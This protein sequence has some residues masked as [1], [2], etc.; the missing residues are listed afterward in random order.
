MPEDRGDARARGTA[1]GPS[2]EISPTMNPK[3]EMLWESSPSRYIAKVS[4]A[5]GK[6]ILRPID[7]DELLVHAH[8]DKN[9][10]DVTAQFLASRLIEWT[11]NESAVKDGLRRVNLLG[12]K[13][14]EAIGSATG[15]K[16]VEKGTKRLIGV[17]DRDVF[18]KFREASHL[19]EKEVKARIGKLQKD[20]RALLRARGRSP[21][22]QVL[23]TGATGFL[24]KEILAQA[25][26]DR[27]IE[28]LVSV[29]RPEK[30]RDPKTKEVVRIL[31]PAQRGA[32]LLRRL[33]IA[34]AKAKKFVFVDGDIE[35]PDLGIAPKELAR[36]RK[37][38][39]HVIHC[40]ASVSFDD[41]YENSFRANVQGA[42][43]ALQFALSLQEARGS[44]FIQHIAI[45]TSYIHGRKKKTTA[46]ESALVFPRN[47]YNNFYELTKAM[48][49]L[50]TDY[51]LVEKG[52]RVSQL[53]PSIVIGHSRTG[54]NRGDTKV[55]NAPIN[56]FGRSKEAMDSLQADAM[57]RGKAWLIGAI[58]SSFPGDRSAE[59]N[60]VPV[61][62]VVQGILAALT[63][64]E[65]IG[66][67][68]HL[69]TDNR[70]RSEDIARITREEIG[71]NVRLADPT[72]FRNITLPIVKAALERGGEPKLANALEKLGTIFGGYGEWGQPIHDVGNDVRILGLPVRR[73]NTEHAFRMLC[74]HNKYVQDFGKVRDLDEIARRELLWEKVLS[75]IENVTGRQVAS[76][77]PDEFRRFLVQRIELKEFRQR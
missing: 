32:I 28:R 30:I 69:A 45:E 49:S 77:P 26:T 11:G 67:R 74:R 31:S 6:E 52:L 37:S 27:R 60:L 39:T 63:V 18:F 40:A 42:L 48:A 64:P 75:S 61:D 36:L 9:P 34:G 70:I 58:A 7:P 46:Q 56:A 41:T 65:S 24:G 10:I 22:L 5:T 15:S 72:L 1:D 14:A 20:A 62:R 13:L 21:R 43:N 3:G 66:E 8:R 68:I 54:N 16:A 33:H 2:R 51:K 47:F 12:V 59:L 19:T 44:R 17:T 57:G 23:L 55:V 73:P 50:E 71:I 76:L 4:L 25:A 53:L 35:K 29:V 38:L